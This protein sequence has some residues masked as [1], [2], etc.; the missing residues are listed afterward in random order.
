MGQH[1]KSLQ[2]VL[3]MSMSSLS[4]KIRLLTS[5]KPRGLLSRISL[6]RVNS[7]WKTQTSLSSW[8]ATSTVL[9]LDGMTPRKRHRQGSS[10]LTTPTQIF[11]Q[12]CCLFPH[13]VPKALDT[14][15]YNKT[16]QTC[17]KIII[18]IS[19]SQLPVTVPTATIPPISS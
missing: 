19:S 2:A 16:Q 18:L 7:S 6:S 1:V 14:H 11:F 17:Y 4:V 13:L 15:L 10:F 3:R 9:R 12:D 5:W 8:T